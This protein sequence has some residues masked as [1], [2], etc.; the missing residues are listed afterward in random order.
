MEASN[1]CAHI[2]VGKLLGIFEQGRT[3]P[4]PQIAAATKLYTFAPNILECSEW[5]FLHVTLLAAR[6]LSRVLDYSK[7]FSPR[8]RGFKTRGNISDDRLILH[9]GTGKVHPK[10]GHKGPERE[11]SYSSILSLTSALEWKRVV[12]A[13]SQSLYPLEIDPVPIVKEVGRPH[14]RPGRLQKISRHQDS[15]PR[16]SSQ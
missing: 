13:T 14:G 10:T 1:K 9:Y 4:S 8:I 11:L 15:I 3:N 16:P 7:I 6:S 5:N 12:N 2:L